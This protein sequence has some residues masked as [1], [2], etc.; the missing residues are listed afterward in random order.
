[1][2]FYTNVQLPVS[3][4]SIQV[5]EMNMQEYTVLQ[6]HLLESNEADVAQS[7]LNI[8]QLC[9]KQDIKHLCNVDAFYILCKIRT[10]SLSDELQFVFNGANIKCSLEDCIQKMQSMDFNCKKVLLVNDMPIELNLPQMLN[11]K[12]Y[13]DVLES[14]IA[15]VGGIELHSLNAMDRTRV[16]NSLPATVIEQCVEFI[17][18]GFAAMQHHW[19][20]QPNEAVDTPGI[21]LN[22]FNNSLLEI[23]KFIF[24]DDLMNTYNLKYILASKLNITPAQADALSPVECRIYVSLL[25][26]EVSKQNKQLQDQNNAAKYNL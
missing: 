9:C 19:F 24:K 4:Q 21:E 5:R 22:A 8:A 14:V 16:L 15:K 20:I 13:A 6:K 18:K 3:K 23:L 7:M 11:I 10:M 25:N 26:D 17:K 2:I 12:D 1:M